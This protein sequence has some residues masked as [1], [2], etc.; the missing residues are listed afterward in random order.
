MVY[1]R[2]QES[3]WQKPYVWLAILGIVLIVTG[4]LGSSV[5]RFQAEALE[6]RLTVLEE[7]AQ[8]TESRLLA[9]K[10][11]YEEKHL[12][13]ADHWSVELSEALIE[14]ERSFGQEGSVFQLLNQA[15]KASDRR[16]A[17]KLADQAEV[18]LS[19]T[20]L[21]VDKILGPPN[22]V[23]Q[24][25]Y[26]ILFWKDGQAQT[27]IAEGQGKIPAIL[28][29]LNGKMAD[30]WN[31]SHGLS[32][33][34]AYAKL[35]EAEGQ[36]II[37][38]RTLEVR[39][40]R[41]LVDRPLAFDQAE[42]VFRL[43]DEALRLAE[44]DESNARAAW[45]AIEDAKARIVW[46]RSYIATSSYQ[47]VQALLMLPQ[48]ESTL[49]L[50]EEAFNAEDF[51]NAK[52]YAEEAYAQTETSWLMAATPT[53]TPIPIQLDTTTNDDDDFWGSDGDDGFGSDDA[54]GGSDSDDWGGS[55]SDSW[56][57][58]GSDSDSWDSDW[59]SDSGS[60]DSDW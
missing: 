38:Q 25:L 16:E 11:E 26:Q 54:W 41:N 9:A 30:E 7:Q 42:I 43:A 60:W 15:R 29:T 18:L 24:G 23:D 8:V 40:E 50:A 39:I 5:N 49:Q 36:L 12:L 1:K 37:A 53:P 58:W 34:S 59:G 44:T 20:I 47:Q 52:R 55:D 17:H 2:R 57:S 56:D 19:T 33:A 10:Q 31:Q 21:V 27:K 28:A 35:A 46:A 13:F 51:V 22:T 45:S 48:A 6:T 14:A 3:V 32:L 4:F